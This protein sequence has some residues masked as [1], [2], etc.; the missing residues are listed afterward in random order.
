L[1]RQTP[2]EVS[3]EGYPANARLTKARF[4]GAL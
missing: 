4:S 1:K 2:D 3:T